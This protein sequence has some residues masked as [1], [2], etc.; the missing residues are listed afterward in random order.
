M[1]RFV[2]QI[3]DE[4]AVVFVPTE[5]SVLLRDEA[6]F[7]PDSAKVMVPVDSAVVTIPDGG[8]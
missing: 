7:L 4:A 6:V 1:I 3:G 2:V 8:V 5:S